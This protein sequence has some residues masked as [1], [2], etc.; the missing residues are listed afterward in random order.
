MLG[1]GFVPIGHKCIFL[2][3]IKIWKC[4][5]L[6]WFLIIILNNLYLQR[7]C[8]GTRSLFKIVKVPQG[9]FLDLGARV[10]NF[11]K[12]YLAHLFVFLS[13]SKSI[14]LLKWLLTNHFKSLKEFSCGRNLMMEKYY[15]SSIW[16]PH[17]SY[18]TSSGHNLVNFYHLEPT[19]FP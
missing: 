8:V 5:W 9:I 4:L 15:K 10:L 19:L 12:V 7:I 11:K 1:Q 16:I 18:V 6:L 13:D 17:F 2:S 3:I 14:L